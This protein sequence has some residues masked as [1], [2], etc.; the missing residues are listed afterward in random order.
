MSVTAPLAT[1]SIATLLDDLE[2]DACRLRDWGAALRERLSDGGRVLVLGA[3]G[4]EPHARCLVADLRRHLPWITDEQVMAFDDDATPGVVLDRSMA[5][6]G[7]VL[8]V[9]SAA[10]DDG[11]ALAALAAARGRGVRTIAFTGRWPNP[12][13]AWSED[14]YCVGSSEPDAIG[15]LLDVARTMLAASAELA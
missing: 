4:T 10:G 1:T 13:A 2:A 7:D 3:P 15:H 9:F 5:Q 6:S 12:L 11:I 8:I 14:A